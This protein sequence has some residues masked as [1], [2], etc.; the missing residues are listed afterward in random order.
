MKR[1][2]VIAHHQRD[3]AKSL[4]IDVANW[5]RDRGHDVWVPSSDATELALEVI[6][7]DHEP[8]SADLVLSLGGDGT[9]LRAVKLLGGEVKAGD[10]IGVKGDLERGQMVFTPQPEATMT[11]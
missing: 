7:G 5:L 9:M 6:A 1:V 2:M 3:D 8:A 11:A 4:A 10:T